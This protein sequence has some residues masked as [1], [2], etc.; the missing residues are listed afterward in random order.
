VIPAWKRTLWRV[1]GRHAFRWSPHV[2]HG[3]RRRLLRFFGADIHATFKMRRAARLDAPW[4]LSAG[5]LVIVGDH[6]R[7]LG[8]GPITL[9]DRCV[10]SQL[11]VLASSFLDPD[12]PDHPAR[13]GGIRVGDEAWVA[14]DTLVL[15]GAEVSDGTVVGA[16]SLVPAGARTEPWTVS[17][18][19]PVRALKERTLNAPGSAS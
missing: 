14:T 13:T 12:E 6:A 19:H 9:G 8:P 3:L 10:V 7:L 18:G 2:T 16:R 1:A 15:A 17:A 11:A 4:A 5:E